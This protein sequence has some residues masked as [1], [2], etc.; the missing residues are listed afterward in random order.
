MA[1]QGSI[2][3]FT[4]TRV[5]VLLWAVM[6]LFTGL[7]LTAALG[8]LLLREPE[9]TP[10]SSAASQAAAREDRIA[11]FEARAAADPIDFLSLNVL[12]GEYLQRGRETGD[13]KNYQQAEAAAERSLEILPGDNYA[14]LVLLGS[15]R[16]VQHDY[17]AAGDLARQALPLKPA[18]AAAYGLLADSEVG[19]GEYEAANDTLSQMRDLDGGLTTT[20]RMAN[21]AFLTGDRINTVAYW[22][23]AIAAGDKL[24]LENQAWAHVQLG[25]TYFALGDYEAAVKQHETALRLFPNYVHALAGLGQA[26]AAQG[27]LDGAIAAYEAAVAEQ[28][29]PQYVTALGDVYAAAGRPD[30]AESQYAL[31]EAIAA[32]YRDAGI[33]T[34]LQ[35]A[36]FY[37]DHDRELSQALSM[38][39]AA[40][41]AAPNVYS[42]DALA[43]AL[44]K[45]G[46]FIEADAAAQGRDCWGRTRS[47]LLLPRRPDP[48]LP[49]RQRRC[50]RAAIDGAGAQPPL[51]SPVRR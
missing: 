35:I 18:G 6:L 47:A 46:R 44:Y 21:L 29:L 4:P 25:V 20:A 41:D 51:L 43:W 36:D 45:N 8:G 13:V 32:L 5:P 39:Q 19:L 42:A 37:S 7:T 24:P 17:V 40:Y 33:N 27:D 10:V 50:A 31:V 2:R 1:V 38:A 49:G 15:V 14:G 26:K 16:L 9:A 12:A 34:D 23:Q 3:R 11:F 30:E 48:A 22:Q 28:P